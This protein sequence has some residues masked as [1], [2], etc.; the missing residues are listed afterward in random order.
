MIGAMQLPLPP[1]A[2]AWLLDATIVTR[3]R[4]TPASRSR[5]FIVSSFQAETCLLYTEACAEIHY[6]TGE[7][8][9]SW[10]ISASDARTVL[11]G[12]RKEKSWRHATPARS[13]EEVHRCG[14]IPRYAPITHNPHSGLPFERGLPIHFCLGRT[15]FLWVDVVAVARVIRKIHKQ[16]QAQELDQIAERL[17][18]VRAAPILGIVGHSR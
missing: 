12:G 15:R 14:H 5:F 7:A 8:E 4:K 10:F 2:S 6:K 18:G 13:V 17:S 16:G 1:W 3:A 11:G 9:N